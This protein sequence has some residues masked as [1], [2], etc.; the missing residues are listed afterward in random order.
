MPGFLKQRYR[1]VPVP[2]VGTYCRYLPVGRYSNVPIHVEIFLH[3]KCQK[4]ERQKYQ[5]NLDL[6]IKVKDPI[7]VKNF[8]IRN[9]VCKVPVG[10]HLCR[11]T[12]YLPDY[13]YST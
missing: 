6:M 9:L 13:T 1:K 10:P 8:R 11:Y 5:N 4:E 12:W 2:T 3:E 7:P